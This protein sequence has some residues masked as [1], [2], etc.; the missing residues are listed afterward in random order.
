MLQDRDKRVIPAVL[1]ALVASKAAG[2]DEVL[3]ERLK[4]R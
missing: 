4:S 1:N 3:L 2:I